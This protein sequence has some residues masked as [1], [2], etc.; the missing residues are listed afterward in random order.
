MWAECKGSVEWSAKH[1]KLLWTAAVVC[2]T[3]IFFDFENNNMKLN[4][5][6]LKEGETNMKKTYFESII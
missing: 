5:Y 3:N 2:K 4:I 1:E 6:I